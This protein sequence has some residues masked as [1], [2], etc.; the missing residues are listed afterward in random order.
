M[1]V[2]AIGFIMLPVYTRYLTPVDYGT[3]E[4]LDLSM[5]LLG[6]VLNMGL[7]AALLRYYATAQTSE[8]KRTVVSTAL[9]FVLGSGAV[10][11][12]LALGFVGPV[13]ALI[14][15]PK[16][17]SAYL[18]I[19]FS[20]FVLGYV[21]NLPRTYLRAL[22]ASRAFV[23]L[24][25]ISVVAILVLNIFFIVVLKSGMAGILWSSL[26]VNAAW[27][28]VV[29][30]T[31]HQVGFSFSGSL[32]RHMVSF[33]L[34]LILSNVALFAL[35]FSDRFFLKHFQSL[36]VV[37]IYAVGYKFGFMMNFL[38]IQPFYGMWQARMYI[39]H[40]NRDHPK[41]F[42]QIF[43]LYSAV[44]IYAGLALSILSP[45]IVR[46]MVES[47]FV[48]I[49][50]IIP[51]IVLAYVFYGI[52]YYVQLGMF[53]AKK[54]NVIGFL[55]ALAAALN[56]GLNY[57]LILHYGM[58]GAASATM[59]SFLA[60]AVG[61]YYF[62]EHNLPLSLGAGRVLVVLTLAICCYLI[63]RWWQPESL[64][65]AL[66][67]KASLIAAFPVLLWK[68]RFL[69]ASEL[70]TIASAWH[71]ARTKISRMMGFA[72]GIAVEP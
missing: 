60:I 2:K 41:I 46:V 44:L 72:H 19:S 48:S 68:G 69:S 15:G 10:M 18:L 66:L 64:G 51:I 16:V 12:S 52:S 56:L 1:I 70:A 3:L 59:L 9:L 27:T 13:S 36:D 29:G 67:F 35:N 50:D 61:S 55:S 30:W 26:L 43:M 24:D 57:V 37:G 40:A 65:L 45:E 17:P 21:A 25:T 8:E 14:F 58:M 63:S 42:G 34:P 49:Q 5:S 39:I 32:L 20:S 23:V 31:F 6:M 11:F 71:D 47:K 38:L 53:L 7:T 54:T 4:I 33:G 28:L 62:S 22:E